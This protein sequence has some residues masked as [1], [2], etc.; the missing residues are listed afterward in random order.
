MLPDQIQHALRVLEHMLVLSPQDR[1]ARG[2][3][4]SLTSLVPGSRPLAVVR[5][6]L[7]LDDKSLYRAIEVNDVGPNAVLLPEFAAL[8]LRTL[9]H[10]P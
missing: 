8:Q 9:E 7:K 2:T 6:S 1:Q 10:A 3:E 4:K 5:R